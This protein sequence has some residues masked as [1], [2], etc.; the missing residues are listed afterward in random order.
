MR[1]KARQVPKTFKKHDF[2][3]KINENEYLCVTPRTPR[4]P[5]ASPDFIEIATTKNRAGIN[6]AVFGNPSESRNTV[7]NIPEP[8]EPARADTELARCRNHLKIMFFLWKSVIFI[9]N[10]GV[11]GS[12]LP[13][14]LGRQDA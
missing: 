10:G 3:V 14:P 9:E 1:Y 2:S 6:L 5:V 12:L 7:S 13:S 11:R 4:P 8:H